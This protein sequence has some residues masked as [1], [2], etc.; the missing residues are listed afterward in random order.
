VKPDITLG[1]LDFGSVDVGSSA[2]QRAHETVTLAREAERL[3]YHAFWISEHRSPTSAWHEAL[4]FLEVLA[5]STETI[6]IGSAGLLARYYSPEV[7]V[8]TVSNLVAAYGSRFDIGVSRGK[9]QFEEQTCSE[10]SLLINLQA[11]LPKVASVGAET[12]ITGNSATS[13][14]LAETFSS[15]W[16]VSTFHAK[17]DISILSAF[18]A[19]GGRIA[20]ATTVVVESSTE[21]PSLNKNPFMQPYVVGDAQVVGEAIRNL[22][23]DMRPQLMMILD[24]EQN[25]RIRVQNLKAIAKSIV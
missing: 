5:A 2:R 10:E 6:R 13:K 18:A 12:W 11:L 19:N 3:G 14:T 4:P 9:S 25:P 17:V 1:V 22:A 20:L 7:V 23:A 21:Q 15:G 16:A 24:L 8:K